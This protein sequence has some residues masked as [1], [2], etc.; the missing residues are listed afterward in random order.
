MC[1]KAAMTKEIQCWPESNSI[2]VLIQCVWTKKS[3]AAIVCKLCPRLCRQDRILVDIPHTFPASLPA[4]SNIQFFIPSWN[5]HASAQTLRG[6]SDSTLSW[7]KMWQMPTCQPIHLKFASS[8][9]SLT[10]LP[11]MLRTENADNLLAILT[12]QQLPGSTWIIFVFDDGNWIQTTSQKKIRTNA[13][14]IPKP[15]LVSGFVW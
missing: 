15:M 11:A 5:A 4:N 14:P 10:Y 9:A 1:L 8:M 13:E 3:K 12:S 2:T 6:R 7:D